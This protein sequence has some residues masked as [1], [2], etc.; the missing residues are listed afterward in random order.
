LT[1]ARCSVSQKTTGVPL[2]SIF[3][4]TKIPWVLKNVPG[5]VEAIKDGTLML[6]TINTWILWV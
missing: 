1:N 4:Y 5:V 3:S 6:G 2:S